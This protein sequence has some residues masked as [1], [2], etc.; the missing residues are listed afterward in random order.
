MVISYR[1]IAHL[2]FLPLQPNDTITGI[3]EDLHFFE[4]GM[5]YV[6]RK[7]NF[8]NGFQD[9]EEVIRRKGYPIHEDPH[10]HHG[11]Y[12]ENLAKKLSALLDV[13]YQNRHYHFKTVGICGTNGKTTTMMIIEK[14]VADK[15]VFSVGT[16]RVKGTKGTFTIRNTTPNVVTLMNLAEKAEEENCEYF[17]M[18]VSSH[19]IDQKRIRYLRFDYLIYT[20]ISRDHLDYHKSLIHYRFSKYKLTKYLKRDGIVI[21]NAD[22]VYFNELKQI[23]SGRILSYG[24]HKAAHFQITDVSLLLDQTSF[25]INRFYFQS[26]LIAMMNVYN[27]S[28][29][30]AFGRMRSISYYQLYKTI[31]AISNCQ[32]RMDCIVKEPVQIYI[33]YAHTSFALQQSLQFFVSVKKQGQNLI[34]VTGCGGNR[35]KEKRAE[36]GYYASYYSDCAIFTEDNAREEAIGSILNDMSARVCD[37]VVCIEQRREALDYAL[38]IAKKNDIILVSGKGDEKTLEK[39]GTIFPFD[40]RAVMLSLLGEKVWK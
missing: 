26:K 19:A 24:Y 13:F 10:F 30:I 22:E 4:E 18:E 27:L 16:H 14:I 37:N 7:G 33:D 1:K 28:A 20:T 32:G 39:N 25:Y 11:Y 3:C 9:C 29:A 6:M 38:N 34:V 5:L 21:A 35:E 23:Y 40:D 31:N 12:V 36:I 17:I 2:I 15:Y 8:Y